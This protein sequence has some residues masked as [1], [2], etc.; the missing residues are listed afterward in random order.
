MGVGNFE[1]CFR[2]AEIVRKHNLDD[3]IRVHPACGDNVQN[4][5]ERPNSAS[6]VLT[7]NLVSSITRVIR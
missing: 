7:K 3:K 4:E 5:V 6:R 1:V 2:D